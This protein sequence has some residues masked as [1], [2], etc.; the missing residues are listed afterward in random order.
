M[1]TETPEDALSY[2]TPIGFSYYAS[3][4]S[5]TPAFY[6][7]LL[8]RHWRRSGS[9]LYRPNQRQSCCPHYTIRLDSTL[10]KPSRDQRQAVNRF[11]NHVLGA[12]YT[13]AAARLYPRSR[14]E[15]KK[16]ET[17]FDLVERIRESEREHLK[18]PPEPAH[19]FTVT[20]EEDSFTEEKFQVY[21]NYQRVVHKEGP[22]EITR[23]GF[24]R[25]LCDSPVRRQVLAT[26]EGEELRLGSYHQC[27]S[28]DGKL[29]A[30]GVLDLLPH[31]VS[32]VYFLYHESIH[33]FMPGK[34]GALREIALAKDAGYRYWYPGFYIHSCPKMRYKIDYMPQYILDPETLQWDLLD[35]HVLKLLDENA[36]VS[37]SA[38]RRKKDKGGDDGTNEDSDGSEDTGTAESGSE[39]DGRES[40][41]LF[42]TDM[43]GIATLDEIA[44]LDLDQMALRVD[45]SGPLFVTSDLVVWNTQTVSADGGIKSGIAELIA[46]IGPDLVDSLC[47]DF[48]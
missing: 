32:S 46:A 13:A 47:L 30:I 9:L 33:K 20:L 38:E 43:P 18:A 3:T 11:N 28:L 34:L 23:V 25:F 35:K 29:V 8:D 27:Y 22:S 19:R 17:E 16:R 42:D 31:C 40:K 7:S 12:E 6:Q 4:S 10:F 41:L 36:Y 21:E 48:S 2:I 14:A 24:R 15:S 45:K 26:P 1:E 39:R 37:L 44:A 5:M